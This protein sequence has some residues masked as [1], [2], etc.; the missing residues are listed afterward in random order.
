V[1]QRMCASAGTPCSALCIILDSLV[2]L[3]VQSDSRVVLEVIGS[4][5]PKGRM[6]WCIWL[7]H[8]STSRKVAGLIPDG[9]LE[10][11]VTQWGQLIV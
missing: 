2:L 6:G 11:S 7:R 9:A 4:T 1:M 5:H 3:P 10:F 8:C